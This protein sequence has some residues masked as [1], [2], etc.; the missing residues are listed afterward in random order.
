MKGVYI[1]RNQH[2][3]NLCGQVNS[4]DITMNQAYKKAQQPFTNAEG[5]EEG[6]FGSGFGDWMTKAKDSGWID[7]SLGLIGSLIK[8]PST[9]GPAVP[10]PPPAPTPVPYGKIAL[11]SIGVIV[12]IVGIYFLAKKK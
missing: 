9:A 8:K 4:G 2:F 5:E 1:N 7:Q 12:S 11:I 6:G 10:P 3:A